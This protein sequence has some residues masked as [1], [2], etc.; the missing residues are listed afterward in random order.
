[1]FSNLETGVH[2]IIIGND[3][4]LQLHQK[5]VVYPNEQRVGNILYA[6]IRYMHTQHIQKR[7][8]FSRRSNHNSLINLFFFFILRIILFSTVFFHLPGS[9]CN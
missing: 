6:G 5:P 9:Q 3:A 8:R 7:E 1:M 4:Q 2:P